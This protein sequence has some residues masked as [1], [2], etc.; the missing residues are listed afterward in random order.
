MK[1]KTIIEL[2]RELKQLNN[3]K[4]RISDK[5]EI[6]KVF[7]EI[8]KH[9][10]D[11][12]TFRDECLKKY[13]KY[14]EEEKSYSFPEVDNLN[15]FN[16]EIGELLEKDIEINSKLSFDNIDKLETEYPYDKLHLLR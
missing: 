7:E 8:Q 2:S 3:E 5:W 12:N 11:F 1:L 10:E 4:L 14:S 16:S 13:G 15:T 6:K 9:I